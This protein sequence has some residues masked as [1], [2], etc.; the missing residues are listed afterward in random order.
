VNSTEDYI[1][2]AVARHIADFISTQ[3]I[4]GVN[5]N[6]DSIAGSN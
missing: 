3:G 4:R 5:A 2:S 1:G 6:T